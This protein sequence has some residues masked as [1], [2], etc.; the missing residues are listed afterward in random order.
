MKRTFSTPTLI[1]AAIAGIAIAALG[2]WIAL[3]GMHQSSAVAA[4]RLPAAA[5]HIASGTAALVPPAT[6]QAS[7]PAVPD[8]AGGADAMTPQ[9]KLASLRTPLSPE[10]ASDPFTVSSWLP[11]P[12]PPPPAPAPVPEVKPAPTAPPLPFAYVGAQNRDTDKPR[13]FLSSGDRLLIVS[14]GE[15]IDGQYRIESISATGV[16]FTYLPLNEKQVMSI[17]GEGAK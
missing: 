15:M 5:R 8:A 3:P 7:Q 17:Q 9:Q 16:V 11:P 6:R 13:V 1:S 2:Y 4:V 14:P 12:P 10:S